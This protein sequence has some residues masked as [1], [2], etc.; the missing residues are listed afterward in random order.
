MNKGTP[1]GRS[2]GTPYF[3]NNPNRATKIIIYASDDFIDMKKGTPVLQ[4]E[5]DT[6]E[7]NTQYA[8]VNTC[9]P[10]STI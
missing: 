9:T 4:T 1:V 3:H 10:N 2:I 5:W 6:Y 7:G 8:Y